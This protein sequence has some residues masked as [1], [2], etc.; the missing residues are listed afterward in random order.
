M[1]RALGDDRRRRP[2]GARGR[3]RLHRAGGRDSRRGIP[4]GR[5]TPSTRSTTPTRAG[6]STTA[7][8]GRATT[9]LPRVLL[10][11]VLQRAA[12]DE[13]DRGLP[14]A[15]R[16][17]PTPETLADSTRAIS[18]CR[19]ERFRE[20]CAR[21]R[22]P[23]LVI[24]GDADLIRPHAQGAALAEVTGGTLVTLE[25]SGHLPTARDP[26]K[27]NLLLRDFVVPASACAA[28]GARP[29]PAQ[30]GALR[31]LAHRTRPRAARRRDRGRAAQAPPR[32]RD[33]L[34]R[35]APGDGSRS[36]AAASASTR[37]ARTSASESGHFESESAEHDLHCFHAWRRMDEI[38]VSNFMVFHDLVRERSVRPLDRRRGLG[39]R[40]L[41]AREPGAED[42]VVRRGSPTSS[43]GC[44][45][46]T[47]ASGRR[48]PDR[49]LQRRDD[50]AH[51]AL[52]PSLRDR[53]LFVGDPEDIVT[54]RFGPTC[55]AIRDWTEAA[56]RRSPAT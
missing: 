54:D 11:A 5:C 51:R 3:D 43:A 4:G 36:S 47:A 28:L 53:A 17:R 34:A 45:C 31:L 30:A 55:P 42:G 39:A 6:R 40:P 13:A 19:T 37:Q 21:V 32:P 50:R 2:P 22:C 8:S 23:V 9:G 46:R 35:A 26:V 20:T 1:R 24:H 16:S 29:R 33:R 52:S 10:R 12:L 25:G 15:G 27:V 7:T 44:R 18:L 41:P 48:L 56:L 14:S 49:R 38:L